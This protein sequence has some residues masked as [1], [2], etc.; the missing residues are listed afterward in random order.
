LYPLIG[1]TGVARIRLYDAE[2]TLL[3]QK[4][5]D[6]RGFV[7]PNLYS[8][9]GVGGERR[10]DYVVVDAPFFLA[11]YVSVIDDRSGNN[12]THA[13]GRGWSKK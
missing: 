9:L 10:G 13:L 8:E 1:E 11:G 4:D 3:N 5:L 12:V 6:V 2:G 7:Q